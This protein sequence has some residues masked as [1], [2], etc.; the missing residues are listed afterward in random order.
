MD[1]ASFLEL[2]FAFHIEFYL[3]LNTF[4]QHATK[5]NTSGFQLN[6]FV[7]ATGFWQAH[8]ISA[9]SSSRSLWEKAMALHQET[10]IATERVYS[11]FSA[12]SS[13]ALV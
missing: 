13:L 4:V 6:G 7:G 10:N 5:I 9:I 1:L 2:D 11:V 8:Y 3:T 12:F